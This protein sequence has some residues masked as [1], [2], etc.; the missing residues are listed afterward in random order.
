MFARWMRKWPTSPRPDGPTGVSPRIR[1]RPV[2]QRA[3][4]SSGTVLDSTPPNMSSAP[5]T[6]PASHLS[7]TTATSG[8]ATAPDAPV[9][10]ASPRTTSPL[11]KRVARGPRRRHPATLARTLQRVTLLSLVAVRNPPKHGDAPPPLL[12]GEAETGVRRRPL[13]VGPV[14]RSNSPT[15]GA[16]ISRSPLSG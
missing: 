14:R 15:E 9:S 3:P 12:P 11:P 10:P 8:A 7:P 4:D 2:R 5:G 16:Q 13:T 1:P 6:S